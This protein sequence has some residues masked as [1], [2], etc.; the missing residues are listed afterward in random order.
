[1]CKGKRFTTAF[2]AVARNDYGRYTCGLC[3]F[4]HSLAVTVKGRTHQVN[5]D[6]DQLRQP[7]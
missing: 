4:K 6:V 3:R 2:Y 7:Q 5:A 1:M